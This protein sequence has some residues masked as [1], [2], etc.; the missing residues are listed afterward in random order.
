MHAGRPLRIRRQDAVSGAVEGESGDRAVG[1]GWARID[2][3]AVDVGAGVTANVGAEGVVECD[4]VPFAE[5]G[6][7]AWLA[8]AVAPEA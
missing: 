1:A 8:A 6:G 4:G 3:V 7:R 5:V 2:D